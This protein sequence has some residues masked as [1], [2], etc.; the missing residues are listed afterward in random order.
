[1]EKVQQRKNWIQID[2]KF[3][4]LFGGSCGLATMKGKCGIT[5]NVVAVH[6]MQLENFPVA[7]QYSGL[8]KV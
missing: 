8:Q 6:L 3:L 2:K 5:A 7:S 4:G 1:M